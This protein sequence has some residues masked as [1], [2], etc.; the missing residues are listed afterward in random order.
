MKSWTKPELIVL[1]RG[2]TEERV[3]SA[4]KYDKPT[5][6][7]PYFGICDQYDNGA[8]HQCAAFILS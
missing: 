1:V 3:L 5:G 6:P 2:S 4:C 8:C 7:Y